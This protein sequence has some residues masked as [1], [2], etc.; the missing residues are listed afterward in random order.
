[1]EIK[2]IRTAQDYDAA[3]RRIETLWGAADS[4]PDTDSVSTN[5]EEN[6]I[7]VATNT[8]QPGRRTPLLA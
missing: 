6:P 7:R 2:P 3:L 5:I 1:M 4:R 8:H